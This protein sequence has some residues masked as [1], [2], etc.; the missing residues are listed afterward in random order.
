LNVR[1]FTAPSVAE[2]LA[3]V[4]K[5]LGEE[6]VILRTRTIKEKGALAL[7]SRD[8]IEVMAASPDRSLPVETSNPEQVNQILKRLDRRPDPRAV[9]DLK[10]ELSELKGHVMTLAEQVRVDRSSKFPPDV[11]RCQKSMTSLGVDKLIALELSEALVHEMHGAGDRSRSAED[12]LIALLAHK[13]QVRKPESKAKETARVIA[14][15]GP[16]GVGKTTTLA[17]LVTSYRHWGNCDTAIVS[18]DTY[19]VAALEQIKTFAAIAG[20]PMEAV[21]TPAAM[22]ASIARHRSRDAIFV[23]TPGRSQSDGQK[24]D[25]LSAFLEAAQTDERLLCLAV[26]T[27]IEDQLDIIEHY[28]K[29]NP[30]GIIFTKFDDS[31]H[32]GGILGVAS[33][34]SIPLAYLTCGQ[35]VPDDVV[36]ADGTRLAELLVYPDMLSRLQKERFTSWIESDTS[37]QL[38]DSDG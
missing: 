11:T 35:N 32:P 13:F 12:V 31:R 25:E 5:Q 7:R 3:E 19:R 34:C 16:T 29:L 30:T 4:K 37:R 18:A 28:G 1:K 17:K 33:A 24:L 15:V 10:D 27:R 2:A 23:D 26:N 20:L 21:Y 36:E 14:L 6:A 9:H 8:V 38:R 22:P